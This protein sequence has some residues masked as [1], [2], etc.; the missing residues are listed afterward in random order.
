MKTTEFIEQAQKIQG[1]NK[2]KD[3]NTRNTVFVYTDNKIVARVHT[4]ERFT[5]DTFP[6]VFKR[7]T[8]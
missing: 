3:D 1:I 6:A 4:S 8:E 2:A 7:L 5:F